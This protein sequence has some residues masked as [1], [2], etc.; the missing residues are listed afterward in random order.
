MEKRES[1]R[2]ERGSEE[3]ERE[4]VDKIVKIKSV[5]KVVKGGSRLGLDEIVV[6]GEKKGRVGLGNGKESEVKE[7]I[8]KEKED[9][10]REMIL[11]KM[12]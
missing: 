4:L 9:E 7:D 12:S 3:R 5:E 10:K 8:S 2:E 6:V 1:K 11:V